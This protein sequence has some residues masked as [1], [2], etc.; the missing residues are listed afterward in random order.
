MLKVHHRQK[1]ENTL[2]FYYRARFFFI[3][4]KTGSEHLCATAV[5]LES[6]VLEMQLVVIMRELSLVLEIQ[7]VLSDCPIFLCAG[8]KVLL[9]LIPLCGDLSNKVSL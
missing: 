4:I 1:V 8:T 2:L 6:L 7:L 3:L 9:L 5:L